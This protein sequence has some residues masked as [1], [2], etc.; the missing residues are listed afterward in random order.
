MKTKLIQIL[1]A[2]ASIVIGLGAA[3]IN[4]LAQPPAQAPLTD[5]SK[6]KEGDI[7]FIESNSKRAPAIKKLTGSNLTHCGIV[8]HDK[9]NNWIVYEGAGYPNTYRPLGE[10]I[11]RES[12]N[13]NKN[14]I[15]VKRLKDRE[16]RLSSKI[17]A[18]RK[19][20]KELHD[21][22]YDFGFA[23]T[24]KN[25]SGKEYIYCSELIWKAFQE[26]VGVEL[27][28]KHPLG[29]YIDN[30]PGGRT[31]DEVKA[32]F[33]T[34]LNSDESKACG[35]GQPYERKEPAI[36]PVEV[37]ESPELDAVTDTSQ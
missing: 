34:Y 13:G 7:V 4:A 37:F 9:Q 24:N 10:W 5:F 32:D 2:S 12:G 23:W 1:I 16:A 20:A 25:G 3:S 36:S 35:K 15:Y 26:K 6:L 8:F 17:E 33:E 22:P 11:E 31:A 21:T 18:L 19:R 28:H 27:G 30:P 14:P 29:D